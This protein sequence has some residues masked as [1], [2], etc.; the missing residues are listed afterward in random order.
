MNFNKGITFNNTIC[1]EFSYKICNMEENNSRKRPYAMHIIQR[2]FK[3]L[4]HTLNT[5]FISV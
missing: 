2:G 5:P 4:L 3:I 1:H